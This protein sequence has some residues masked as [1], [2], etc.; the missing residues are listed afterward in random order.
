[1]RKVVTDLSPG[2]SY[3]IQIRSVSGGTVS[4]WSPVYLVPA[5]N[6]VALPPSL[7]NSDI[8]VST[9]GD[10][11]FANWTY[12]AIEDDFKNYEYKWL[13]YDGAAYVESTT[14]YSTLAPNAELD[15]AT[16]LKLF[17]PARANIKIS[18]R[19]VDTSGNASAWATS[20]NP[21]INAA[22]A[23]PT[24][25]SA[26][27]AIDTIS[28]FWTAPADNDIDY[29][30]LHTGTA[31]F[32]PTGSTPGTG[33]CIAISSDTNFAYTT[34][35]YT[36]RV[37]AVRAVDKFKTPG[38]KSGE[39]S[40]AASQSN[41]SD[42][43]APPT[44][45][46]LSLSAGT[47]SKSLASINVSWN[48]VYASAN[49][50]SIYKVRYST[51]TSGPWTYIPVDARTS[52]SADITS[53]V[54]SSLAPSS[55]YYVQIAAAD[56]SG[57]ISAYTASSSITTAKN[58]TAPSTPAPPTA[59]A[60]GM[61]IQVSHDNTKAAGGAIE[62]DVIGYEVYA[63]TSIGTYTKIG[64]L[65]RSTTTSALFS[66]TSTGG[67][68]TQL[69][70]VNVKAVNSSSISSSSASTDAQ[71]SPTLI[72]GTN[73][74]NATI[75]DAQ[76]GNL[77][78][79]RL[80]SGTISADD[81]RIGT[82]G[83]KIDGASKTIE[84]QNFATGNL[85]WII[86]SDGSAEFNNLTVRNT[87]KIEDGVTP[88]TISAYS[89]TAGSS[90]TVFTANGHGYSTG[91]YV[92]IS[93]T[94]DVDTG[95]T[96]MVITWLSNNTFSG[97]PNSATTAVSGITGSAVKVDNTVRL[98]NDGLT[99]GNSGSGVVSIGPTSFQIRSSSTGTRTAID[100]TGISVYKSNAQVVGLNSDGTF[101][102]KS[103]VTGNRVELD[104]DNGLRVKD[105]DNNTIIKV[106]PDGLEGYSKPTN[107]SAISAM[108]ANALGS[109][110]L[111][112]G[113]TYS[114]PVTY[115]S[116]NEGSY[117]Y[118]AGN[119]F[120]AGQ[121]VNIT[122]FTNNTAYNLSSATVSSSDG[123]TFTVG[124]GFLT[125]PITSY[126]AS[127]EA[128]QV[129]FTGEFTLNVDD[130]VSISDSVVGYNLKNATVLD[131]TPTTF[132]LSSPGTPDVTNP[133]NVTDGLVY[134]LEKSESPTSAIASYPGSTYIKTVTTEDAH[135]FPVGSLV[136]VGVD[137]NAPILSSPSATT[138][139]YLSLSNN[140]SYSN[141]ISIN[142]Y[143]KL[144]TATDHGLKPGQLFRITG[145]T[146][147]DEEPVE[148]SDVIS[149]NTL[150]YKT[151]KTGASGTG[152]IAK[153]TFSI[154]IDGAATFGGD[155]K[156][157]SYSTYSLTGSKLSISENDGLKLTRETVQNFILN[158]TFSSELNFPSSENW[159]SVAS[160]GLPAV[161][162]GESDSGMGQLAGAN[163]FK[164]S[165]IKIT[166]ITN[167]NNSLE[168]TVT[169][170]VNHGLAVPDL[171]ALNGIAYGSITP[172][173]INYKETVSAVPSNTTFKYTPQIG[174][175]A[176]YITSITTSG[177]TKT[178]N[179]D[180]A[181]NFVATQKVWITGTSNSNLNNSSVTIGSTPTA[182]S[183]T[184]VGP[185]SASTASD[186][187]T[188][189]TAAALASGTYTF[190][191]VNTYSPGETVTISGV[192]SNYNITGTVVTANGTQFTMVG[193]GS[194]N[195]WNKVVDVT[196]ATGLS[197]YVT[198]GTTNNQFSAGDTVTIAGLST[199]FNLTGV[200]IASA[201]PT[202][203][204]VAT[205]TL[206]GQ[207][208]NKTSTVSA[209]I[210]T[211]TVVT[212]TV[213]SG[214]SVSNGSV[215]SITGTSS[216]FNLSS[217]TVTGTT[218]TSF[219]VSGS[220]P[221]AS[222]WDNAWEISSAE[223][224]EGQIT[225]TTSSTHQ[226]TVGG[227][228]TIS[229]ASSP[230]NITNVAITSASGTTFTVSTANSAVA[231]KN[232]LRIESAT[233]NGSVIT[234][235][236]S[237]PHGFYNGQYVTVSGLNASYNVSG[238][239]SGA[240]GNVFSINSTVTTTPSSWQ[241]TIYPTL[242][243]YSSPNL[244]LTVPNLFSPGNQVYVDNVPTL[245]TGTAGHAV[246]GN[247]ATASTST[248]GQI[249]LNIGSLTGLP[250]PVTRIISYS[251]TATASTAVA[252]GS[253]AVNI[254][255]FT[256]SGILNVTSNVASNLAFDTNGTIYVRAT[257]FGAAA[258][259]PKRFYP[260]TYTGK[261]GTTFT[262]CHS[263]GASAVLATFDTVAISTYTISFPLSSNT[264]IP[265]SET[266]AATG[267]PA[268][269]FF[270][271][272]DSGGINHLV[273]YGGISGQ[274]FTNCN[275][276]DSISG[277][278]NAYANIKQQ[279]RITLNG[280][281]STQQVGL[282]KST[283]AITSA[284][285]NSTT[286]LRTYNTN[287]VVPTIQGLVVGD[288]VDVTGLT[289]TNS[290]EYNIVEGTIRSVTTTSFVVYAPSPTSAAS[291]SLT[292][293]S[294]RYA[295]HASKVQAFADV[296]VTGT[297][298][299]NGTATVSGGTAST[300]AAVGTVS[301]SGDSATFTNSSI[302]SFSSSRRGALSTSV[303][304]PNSTSKA[305]TGSFWVYQ[306]VENSGMYLNMKDFILDDGTTAIPASNNNTTFSQIIPRGSWTRI[307]NIFSLPSNWNPSSTLKLP[308]LLYADKS[309]S[310]TNIS[311]A[312]TGSR[313]ATTS[314]NH[315]F[316][317]GQTVTI[318]QN[319]PGVFNQI[320]TIVT[321]PSPNTF[322]YDSS[323]SGTHDS[324][325]TTKATS[326]SV[327]VNA[328]AYYDGTML[329]LTNGLTEYFDGDHQGKWQGARGNS[330]SVKESFTS[331]QIRLR[332]GSN[333][334]AGEGNYLS[335]MD[336]ISFSSALP[337]K[338]SP[339]ISPISLDIYDSLLGYLPPQT[340]VALYSGS[341][342]VG[343]SAYVAVTTNGT[344]GILSLGGISRIQG[345]AYMD[346][347][348]VVK[349]TVSSGYYGGTTSPY[350]NFNTTWSFLRSSTGYFG[351]VSFV[352]PPSGCVK[353]SYGAIMYMK[354]FS[355]AGTIGYLAA[356]IS[357][358][359]SGGGT[360]VY[361]AKTGQFIQYS[362][363]YNNT[364]D[365]SFNAYADID[366]EGTSSCSKVDVVSG[367]TSGKT[368]YLQ[369]NGQRSGT[370]QARCARPY[371]VIEPSLYAL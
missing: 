144:V 311:G 79:N 24:S 245:N 28:F 237:N 98:T 358:S 268:T 236:T 343:K 8:Q 231:W 42:I 279:P 271:I 15:Y 129:T 224:S 76:I 152:Q 191:S 367:L 109:I 317:I 70:Y 282:T 283:V 123:S 303:Y 322:T 67:A 58:T 37:F 284:S 225:Y 125:Y 269:G 371:V 26:T 39:V 119:I 94:T 339:S 53:A 46:G 325:Y 49:D 19:A 320:A 110:G 221:A 50:V 270:V 104:G 233:G 163:S 187:V 251:P 20:T 364:V 45:T 2:R 180:V 135:N 99:I 197:S 17:N 345:N 22:P 248:I 176:F 333:I 52:S 336:K 287:P 117:T 254:S 54:I 34:T 363:D 275:S 145:T 219:T 312:G 136:T 160:Y 302:S 370:G 341:D 200:T 38:A 369:L 164:S 90:N 313:T 323:T 63:G 55:T 193:S 332:A 13:Y 352:A 360:V 100:N 179:T 338:V 192:N 23:A 186:T 242:W 175:N 365:S 362:I 366:I 64:F 96:P 286:G 289:G 306:N 331:G 140:V 56:K 259:T 166:S 244:T 232:K 337:Q 35:T 298:T 308:T 81:I 230:Y 190:T 71:A 348:K 115:A 300:T 137:I 7:V 102:L 131:A 293:Q 194:S 281:L 215:I 277:T 66:V 346:G 161:N 61:Q 222:T 169:T 208:L 212:Y 205:N 350:D 14:I 41:N 33:T 12:G 243:S 189:V 83:I 357:T 43:T 59:A 218:P 107:I 239:I 314:G 114:T 262:G 173:S 252:S 21:A 204:T 174:K 274:S 150:T 329:T 247:M 40:S 238:N 111:S 25:L 296:T 229:N 124:A 297:S 127:E 347:V 57:N 178:V 133:V 73:I 153:E 97:S 356:T 261:T 182:T 167:T 147:M 154:N 172:N 60:N 74:V 310:V 156:S 195:T 321:I 78:V 250:L 246:Y 199:A 288:S 139:T 276:L 217:R 278:V 62:S 87:F 227:L 103:A 47:P 183:F 267:W 75:G 330:I 184:Y 368:Y 5:I 216:A 142:G 27:P 101:F 292:L 185:D 158:P 89:R 108:Q 4:Q 18:V 93:G 51:S 344:T 170:S 121:K 228:A 3:S 138:F 265:S 309:F 211:G 69:W 141:P 165:P 301:P 177:T 168:K 280:R 196:S 118:T 16:N 128:G 132:T 146:G 241:R 255:T 207:S 95:L 318:S 257:P 148:V 273:S 256:G 32:T 319:A 134:K 88:V 29:Y 353:I 10:K 9:I 171:V 122:G 30:E 120:T 162:S 272:T 355:G 220:V 359:P 285:Y 113:T 157:S 80:V 354:E 77:N 361:D 258:G 159:A 86:D 149:N 295:S 240:S 340:G 206:S 202:G 315:N 304:L 105:S 327:Q 335:E 91:D 264:T 48:S 226:L 213:P 106:D 85:G 31:G 201:G 234:Y 112:S 6:K 1:M 130:L 334:S 291:S 143:R 223:I 36:T 84:S 324:T 203:F 328:I 155:L 68:S 253:N 92:L 181:H 44:P 198:Y 305:A 11:F 210:S 349:R 326:K 294:G 342:T 249:V 151:S 116:S 209:A 188:T 260:I 72:A 263:G 214:H 266:L 82:D 316:E 299:L 290:S 307:S 351:D 65:P 126:T 235:T